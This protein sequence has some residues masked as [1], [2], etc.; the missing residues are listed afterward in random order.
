V[1]DPV[2]VTVEAAGVVVSAEVGVSVLAGVAEV[3]DGVEDGVEGGVGEGVGVLREEE[4]YEEVE[5]E[6]LPNCLLS[7]SST[8]LTTSVILTMSDTVKIIKI[9]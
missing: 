9:K 3:E 2:G 1:F 8:P 6:D 4:R 5:E 7:L